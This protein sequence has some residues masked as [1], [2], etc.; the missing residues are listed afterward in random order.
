[1]GG[2]GP[3]P[4]PTLSRDAGSATPVCL[5]ARVSVCVCVCVCVC[6]LLVVVV[7]KHKGPKTLKEGLALVKSQKTRAGRALVEVWPISAFGRLRPWEG[8]RLTRGHLK[9]MR[10][11]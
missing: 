3:P 11:S 6:M 2:W 1:M 8:E 9:G 10:L 4:P 5:R 7:V